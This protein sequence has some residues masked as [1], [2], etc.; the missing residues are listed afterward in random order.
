MTRAF[1]LKPTLKTAIVSF[2]DLIV[3]SFIS[4]IFFFKFTFQLLAYHLLFS[5]NEGHFL[6]I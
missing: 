5:Y 6:I 1:S 2:V 3:P 4:L